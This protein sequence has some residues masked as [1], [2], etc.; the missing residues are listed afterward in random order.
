MTEL[1]NLDNNATTPVLRVVR[2]AVIDAM[3]PS[4]ANPSSNHRQG[5]AARAVVE[6]ARSDIAVMMRADADDIIFTSGATEGNDA[7]LRHYRDLPLLT[8]DGAHPSLIGGHGGP[9]RAVSVDRQGIIDLAAFEAALWQDG[10]FIVAIA[11]VNGETGVI[12]PVRDICDL[13]RRHG[14]ITLIDAAQAVGRVPLGLFAF[15]SDY[16][17]ASAHKMNGPK[18][19]GCLVLGNGAAVPRLASGG[20]QERGR[21]SGTENVPSI[22]GFGAACRRRMETLSE[23][24]E[25]MAALRDRLEEGLLSELPFGRIN[26]RQAPRAATST[27]LTVPGV[28]GMALTARL[29][30][31]GVLCSQVSA[32]SSGRPEPSA[33]LVAMGVSEHDAFSTIRLSLCVQTGRDE[34]DSAAGIISRE[35]Q[36]LHHILTGAA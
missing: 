25:R 6:N 26:A 19:V 17:T 20:G 27:S 15:K 22:A 5:L 30:A 8:L 1:I 11:M 35:A 23:D 3:V 16:L 31:A 36:F 7:V 24:L 33:T 4:I 14:S 9:Q 32:C 13:A 29:D 21:R 28:D 12:Q 34:I 10:P 2:S 18:G